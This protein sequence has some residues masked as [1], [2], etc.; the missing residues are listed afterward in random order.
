MCIGYIEFEPM[1]D[2]RSIN[3]N[4][5]FAFLLTFWTTFAPLVYFCNSFGKSFQYLLQIV[6]GIGVRLEEA[7]LRFEIPPPISN[8]FTLT[9]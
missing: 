4:E 5:W 9:K 7:F 6:K 1:K 3:K 8:V 2:F